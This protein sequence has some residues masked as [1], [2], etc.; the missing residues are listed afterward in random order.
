MLRY[1]LFQNLPAKAVGLQA[2]RL[3]TC[4][5]VHE[6]EL[7]GCSTP[8]RLLLLRRNGE[9]RLQGSPRGRGC[10][11]SRGIRRVACPRGSSILCIR[12]RRSAGW[13]RRRV[14]RKQRMRGKSLS[15]ER[16]RRR[17]SA[18]Y[19]KTLTATYGTR[20]K[21][22]IP[23]AGHR[24]CKVRGLEPLAATSSSSRSIWTIIDHAMLRLGFWLIQ[25]PSHTLFFPCCIA[26]QV[27]NSLDF[28]GM[29]I[30]AAHSHFLCLGDP[31]FGNEWA[32]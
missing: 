32:Q 18:L 12:R 24:H 16:R 11:V 28:M 29:F 7:G 21:E 2:D 9:R 25:V 6:L 31:L 30:R 1:E 4:L 22:V 26:D 5:E 14:R 8:A 17:R 20:G 3:G 19:E 27:A 13:R 10:A 23:P 15:S